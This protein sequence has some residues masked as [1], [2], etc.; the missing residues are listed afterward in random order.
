MADPGT[1]SAEPPRPTLSVL[2]GFALRDGAGRPVALKARKNRL[3]LAY[4][5][6]PPGQARSRDQL[7]GLFWGDR[8]D[9]Q[10]RAS[11]R[12]ALSGLRRALGDD[13]LIVENDLVRLRPGWLETDYDRLRALAD[14]GGTVDRL[15]EVCAGEFLAGN[16]LDDEQVTAWLHGMRRECTDMAIALLEAS[17]RKAAERGDHKAALD[18]MRECLALEPL[19]E[20][21]HRAIMQL[22]ADSGER[23]MALAQF[24]SCKE[25]LRHELNAPPAA[26][27]Q[28]LADSI[29]LH[30]PADAAAIR[31]AHALG[32][33]AAQT[34]SRP[35]IPAETRAETRAENDAPAVAVIPFVNMSGDAEQT[36]FADGITEDIITDLSDVDGLKVASKSA[37]GMYRGVRLPPAQIAAEIGVRYILEGSVRK[38]GDHVRISAHLTDA[39]T[40]LS[41]WSQRY[42]RRLENIFDLQAEISRAIVTAL[43]PSLAPGSDDGSDDGSGGGGVTTKRTTANVEA[44]ECYMRG[45]LAL[46]AGSREQGKQAVDLFAQA[47][48][49]DPGYALAHTGM[50]T[51]A[52][53]LVLH[54][55]VGRAMLDLALD[56]AE[57]ALRLQPGLAEAWSA[58]GAVRLFEKKFALAQQDLSKALE[59]S[60]DLAEAHFLMGQYHLNTAGGVEQARHCFQRA[61]ELTNNLRYGIMYQTC[62]RGLEMHD[63]LRGLSEKILT[64]ANRRFLLDPHDMQAAFVIAHS[65]FDSGQLEQARRWAGVAASFDTE[66]G[67]LSYN[68][69]CLHSN[70]GLIDEALAGLETTLRLGCNELKARFMKYTDPDLD[71]VRDDPRFDALLA[72]YGYRFRSRRS[73]RGSVRKQTRK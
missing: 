14:G 2:G 34:E 1:I 62:L 36:Y 64:I 54:Y 38:A 56:H 73:R 49:L 57:T 3:L 24:R 28:A 52:T 35:E 66:D 59:L 63:E 71:N 16:D 72:K 30:D 8:Q 51:A 60:G 44:Y 31:S 10:A 40:N 9:E 65:H 21:T 41:T 46:Q 12:N 53:Q 17:G 33:P 13:A 20:Q 25:L 50:V 45:Q 70:M 22:Y 37:S 69:A 4:L 26:E 48:A 27:T 5:A 7:A 43:R 58:R 19:K 47:I 29:A 42:D 32:A 55:D 39:T 18:L 61:F 6:V 23:A 67:A 11:L 15:D 68:L